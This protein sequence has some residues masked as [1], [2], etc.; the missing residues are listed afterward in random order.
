MTEIEQKARVVSLITDTVTRLLSDA[1]ARDLAIQQVSTIFDSSIAQRAETVLTSTNLSYR[2]G[3]LIQLAYRLAMTN[4][5]VGLD[6]TERQPGARSV[7][8]QVGA[9][10]AENHIPAVKDAYQNIGKN[11]TNLVRGNF[12]EFD[13]LLHWASK[14]TTALGDI[15]S[16][17]TYGC[18]HAA[19]TARSVKQMPQVDRAALSFAKVGALTEELFA[20]GS[21]GAYE[22]FVIA[23][24]LQ[25]LVEQS[26]LAGVRV[27]T[28]TLNAS[29]KSSR[30]AGDI[31]ILS[32]NRVIEAY[33]VTA[34]AWRTKLA[35]AGQTI[36][37]H[38]LTRLNIIARADG[39][40]LGVLLAELATQTNDVAVLDLGH[41]ASALIAT[42][43]RPFR[44]AA[45]VR[46]YEYLDRYQ[47]DVALVNSYVDALTSNKLTVGTGS[48]G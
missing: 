11:S 22:Q 43:T 38:D 2:D 3:L 23:A 35:G 12:G 17:F 27:E 5:T 14:T 46:L 31:Q 6:V 37:D 42:L 1:A 19:R 15:A 7:A 40:P 32:G 20:M 47:P 10:F 29:D 4:P 26:N 41:Y 28:K 8:G 34:N 44:A 13:A 30:A 24:L 36:K 16:V 48:Q 39:E 33:E 45:L 25:A 18:A 21:G 9:F